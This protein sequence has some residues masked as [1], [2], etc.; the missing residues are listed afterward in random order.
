MR[1]PVDGNFSNRL[2]NVGDFVQPG[3]RLANVVPLDDVCIDANYKETQLGRL[4]PDSPSRSQWMVVSGR[5]IMGVVDSLT[6]ASGSVFTLLPPDNA[7]GNFTKIVRR[8]PV[9]IHVPFF[10]SLTGICC[11]QGMS[12]V[13]S[14]ST[15]PNPD[16]VDPIAAAIAIRST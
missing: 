16:A 15:K 9:R 6:P 8:V 3:Q 10:G 2:V 4:K 5:T 14:I 1:T 12:V 13:T 11:V 7:T